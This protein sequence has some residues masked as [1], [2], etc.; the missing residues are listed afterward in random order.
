MTGLAGLQELLCAVLRLF[1]LFSH[2]LSEG[3]PSYG[4]LDAVVV[5]LQLP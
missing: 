2:P 1:F 5:D 4:P 3:W